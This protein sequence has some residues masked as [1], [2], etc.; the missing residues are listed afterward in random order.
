MSTSRSRSATSSCAWRSSATRPI[1]RPA[2]RRGRLVDGLVGRRPLPADRR[3]RTSRGALRPPRHRPVHHRSRG[4]PT[5]TPTRSTATV[6]GWSRR[7]ASHG[8]PLG[9]SSGG[10][11]AQGV[12]LRRPDLVASLT[13]IATAP[14]G[15]VDWSRCRARC[16]SWPRASRTRPR[17][18][19]GPTARQSSRGRSTTSARTPGRSRSTWSATRALAGQ[20]VRP[21]HRRRGRRQPLDRDRQRRRRRRAA[22]RPRPRRTDPGRARHPRPAVPARA[23]ARCWPRRFPAP[24]CW[25]SRDGSPGAAAVDV[26]RG[27]AGAAGAHGSEPVERLRVAEGASRDRSRRRG[28]APGR[29]R[30][31]PA[32]ARRCP[33]PRQAPNPNRA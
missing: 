18:R 32:P 16:R 22:R 14:A 8:P 33:R 23:T 7:S 25:W 15:G 19:T 11:V 9:L 3:R 17:S 1:R 21:Q 13:L 29:G 30:P 6:W 12:A 31:T 26:G 2:R 4:S 28:A 5:T 27:R 24:G 20:V 10:G